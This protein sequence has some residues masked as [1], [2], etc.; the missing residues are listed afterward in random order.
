[1]MRR[2][3][4]ILILSLYLLFHLFVFLNMTKVLAQETA[5]ETGITPA[6]EATFLGVQTANPANPVNQTNE[7][8][9]ANQTNQTAAP[10]V[11]EKEEHTFLLS[12]MQGNPNQPGGQITQYRLKG[13]A[14]TFIQ[15]PP[16]NVNQ[17]QLQ[18]VNNRYDSPYQT[19]S[20]EVNRQ[21]ARKIAAVQEKQ[22]EYY[23][24]IYPAYRPPLELQK[25]QLE[26]ELADLELRR[27]QIQS[28]QQG[29][30]NLQRNDTS[31]IPAPIR[32]MASGFSIQSALTE[33]QQIEFTI[34]SQGLNNQGSQSTIQAPPDQWVQLMPPNSA[35][36]N[37]IWIKAIEVPK[38]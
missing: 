10:E 38:E 27:N 33:D 8:N 23:N 34:T 24:E 16:P 19:E 2:L 3:K 36:Q 25:Q 31:T 1:M 11:P 5:P 15:V 37:E 9:P 35:G 20:S 26:Q 17:N 14:S 21:I 18:Q 12:V 30:I 28:A 32:T 4:K 29:K 22:Q 6:T 13:N 7:T